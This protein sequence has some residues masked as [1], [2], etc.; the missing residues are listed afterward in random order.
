MIL[1]S[2]GQSSRSLLP[3]NWKWFSINN[4]SINQPTAVKFYRMNSHVQYMT[5]IDFRV[6]RS[7]VRVTITLTLKIVSITYVPFG[8]Q[9]SNFIGCLPILNKKSIS[10]LGSQGQRSISI[11]RNI[12]NSFTTVKLH[13]MITYI[14]NINNMLLKFA[15]IILYSW[16]FSVR[17]SKHFYLQDNNL[18][19]V[20]WKQQLYIHVYE[21]STVI[22]EDCFLKELILYLIPMSNKCF[23]HVRA[24]N[25]L[26]SLWCMSL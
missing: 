10:I 14:E 2:Q 12:V 16:R 6:I 3:W 9:G 20:L 19:V 8:L 23:I 5:H 1:G 7:K 18:M 22:K 4:L 13:R 25:A 17:P 15:Y 26:V 21:G 24:Y 11:D